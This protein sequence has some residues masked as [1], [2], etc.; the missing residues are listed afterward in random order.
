MNPNDYILFEDIPDE[1]TLKRIRDAVR[2][3][4]YG[5][6]ERFGQWPPPKDSNVLV[7]HHDGDL[8][9]SRHIYSKRI[10][11]HDLIPTPVHAPLPE[12][13]YIRIKDIRGEEHFDQIKKALVEKGYTVHPSNALWKDRRFFKILQPGTKDKILRWY[14][15]SM[16]DQPIR[17]HPDEIL[18]DSFDTQPESN[19]VL[20]HVYAYYNQLTK[21]FEYHV[22]RKSTLEFPFVHIGIHPIRIKPMNHPEI[23]N[24][25]VKATLKELKK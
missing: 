17:I 9:W 21:D 5:V 1:P 22:D 19:E 2:A 20:L 23:L 14:E 18:E 3:Q 8:Y 24:A 10:M 12:N 4:G 25:I 6:S 16:F 11:L 15:F 13:W 7:L